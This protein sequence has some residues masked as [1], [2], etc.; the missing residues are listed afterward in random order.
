MYRALP[1][2]AARLA[3][4]WASW[5]PRSS[6]L[7]QHQLRQ[8]ALL[9]GHLATSHIAA[10]ACRF[11]STTSSSNGG[12]SSSNTNS[13]GSSSSSSS[14]NGGSNS[15]SSGDRN[16]GSS[17]EQRRQQQGRQRARTS[18]SSSGSGSSSSF[19]RMVLSQVQEDL[20]RNPDL[21]KA[22][23]DL[24]ASSLTKK[25][26]S[27]GSRLQGAAAAAAE[28]AAAAASTTQQQTGR[29]LRHL[30]HVQQRVAAKRQQL[31]DK[32][33][34]NEACR[35][36][37]RHSSKVV[38]GAAAA[39]AVL[40][41]LAATAAS[42]FTEEPQAKQRAAQW[43]QRMA[44]KRY[45]QQQE[46]QQQQQQQEGDDAH[47][48]QQQQQQQQQDGFGDEPR[49][50]ALVLSNETAWDRFGARLRDMPF[51][52]HFFGEQRKQQQQQQSSSSTE[53]VAAAAAEQQQQQVLSELHELVQ[54]VVAEHIVSAY[55]LGDEE[56]LR[57]HC[58]DGAFAALKASIDERNRLQ[59]RLDPS[60]LLLGQVELVGA[61]QSGMDCG[62]SPW[63]V[64]SFD[65]QQINCLRSAT[66][67]Q[68]VQGAKDDIR[69]VVYTIAI[70]R[71]SKP[72]TPGL[73]YPWLEQPQQQLLQEQQRCACLAEPADVASTG[74]RASAAAA[75]TAATAASPVVTAA[76]AAATA[77]YQQQHCCSSNG[78][79]SSVAVAT[80]AA[81]AAPA[82]TTAVV[83]ATASS[84][85]ATASSTVA[86]AAAA[87][88]T[89]TAAATAAALADAEF[90]LIS[91]LLPFDAARGDSLRSIATPF[92]CFLQSPN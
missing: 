11:S 21:Q 80:V 48:Q 52:Q 54:T 73:L 15:S 88:A 33:M 51:L 39:A 6:R 71:H 44:A 82:A 9:Q 58:G 90:H 46:L 49:E 41:R 37:G 23:E 91:V 62:E 72:E 45:K 32:A 31:K 36:I 14:S 35:I 66:T 16:A 40:Q 75:S 74:T 7:L 50:T 27:V 42:A 12:S 29:V 59:L 56:T 83:A 77:L 18:S 60:I 28:A 8:Q 86:T 34:E 20:Q 89:A 70:S 4:S 92:P 5:L 57:L 85:V 67:G 24:K 69:R 47:Q 87:A 19:I 78:C 30:R 53:A 84:T 79:C 10:I 81:A 25:T 38:E 64:Y 1:W 13:S 17:G 3:A 26:Q 63:F 55:L 65:C 76:A 43:R 22:V 61:R 2:G 68:V